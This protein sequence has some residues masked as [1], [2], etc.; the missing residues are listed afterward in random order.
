MTQTTAIVTTQNASRYLQ[1]LCK[2]FAHKVEVQFTPEAG[3][4]S[5]PFGTCKFHA[6]DT[7]L[8]MIGEAKPTQL[9]KIE[10]F[11]GDHLARFAFRENPTI[12]WT[13]SA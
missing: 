5:L 11:L 13:R 2:H 8:T 9:P 3:R 1:K 10:R 6:D 4:V 7:Q 12:T